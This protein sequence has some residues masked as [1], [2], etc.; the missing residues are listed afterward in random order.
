MRSFAQHWRKPNLF[1]L[2]TAWKLAQH[3]LRDD[4]IAKLAQRWMFVRVRNATFFIK[5]LRDDE[6]ICA[7]LAETKPFSTFNCLEACA[8]MDVRS[9]SQCNVF[10]KNFARQ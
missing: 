10:H 8:T 1:R 9:S 5:T 2:S 7:T 3:W 4:G 6:I